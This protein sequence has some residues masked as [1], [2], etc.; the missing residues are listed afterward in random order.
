LRLAP[1]PLLRRWPAWPGLVLLIAA[2]A[3]AGVAYAAALAPRGPGDRSP[4][5]CRG[6]E[7]TIV[8]TAGDDRLVGTP[9]RDVIVAGAGADT[10]VARG[11]ADVVCDNDGSDRV[12]AGAGEDAVGGGAGDD[13]IRGGAGDDWLAGRRGQDVIAGGRGD[14]RLVGDRGPDTLRGNAGDDRLGGGPGNDDCV[15]GDGADVVTEC[16][17]GTPSDPSGPS[18]D[19]PSGPGAPGG[20]PADQPPSAADDVA[21]MPEDSGPRDI[22][23]LTNDPDPDGGPKSIAS[24]SQPANGSVQVTGG[25]TGLTY[26]PD[27]DYC[28]APPGTTD[29]FTYTLAPGGSTASVAVTVTCENDAPSVV[30]S[31]GPLPYTEGAAATAV[32]PLLLLLDAD[33]SQLEGATVRISAGFEAGDELVFTDQPGITGSVAGDTLTLT[34]TATVA[35]YQTALRSV[36]FRHSGDDPSTSRTVLF[37]VDDGGQGS[38]PAFKTIAITPVND[39]PTV[40]VSPGDAEFTEDG[41]RVAVDPDVDVVDPDSTM[42]A[43]ASVALTP[44]AEPTETLAFTAQSGI[45]GGYDPG[46]GV[47]TLIGIATVEDYEAVLRSV[48][49]ARSAQNTVVSFVRF[50]S[51]RVTDAGGLSSPA[52]TRD[53]RFTPVNDAPVVTT[54]NGDTQYLENGPPTPIDDAVTVTDV[55]DLDIEG[56]TVTISEGF[57]AGDELVFSDQN[58]I[59]GTVAGDTLTLSG[60]AT[61]LQYQTALRTTAYRHNGDNPAASR[62]VEFT[63]NDGDA[64]SAPA[65]KN[66]DIIAVNDTPAVDPTDAALAYPEN[67]GPL[68]ADAGIT[69]SDPDSLLQG[70]AVIVLVGFVPAQDELAFANQLGITGIYDDT[71]GTLTLSGTGTVADYQAALR[72]VTYEN[73]SDDPSPPSRTL[74]FRVTDAQGASVAATREVTLGAANDAATIT[75]TAGALAYTEGAVAT[76]VDGGLTVAD[77]D[78][79]NLDGARVRVSAGFDAGDDLVFVNQS[80]ITGVYNNGTGVLTLSGSATISQYQ[81]ALRSVA[82]RSTHDNPATT[83]TVEF[84]ADDGGGLGPAATRNLDVTRVNDAPVVTTT[85]ANL[86]YTENAGPVAIDTG[87]TVTDPDS[88]QLTGATVTIAAPGFSSAQ[89]ELD[90]TDQNGITGAYNDATGVLTLSGTASV[91]NYQTALRSVA[92]TNVSESP[93]ASRTISFQATDSAATSNAATRGIAITAIN[94]PPTAVNDTASTD[95]DTTL[96]VAVPGVLAND[97][98]VDAGDTKTV[99]RLNGN[100]VLTGTSLKGAAVTINANGSYSYNPGSIFQGL[101]TGQSDTDSFTYRMSDSGGASSTATVNLTIIGVSD[102]PVA[103]ADSFD[104]IGNTALSVGTGRPAGEAGKVIT[105]TVLS[106]DTDVDTPQANLVVEPVDNAPTTLGG[107]ITFEADGNFTY[108]P[109]D[110]DVGVTDTFTYRVCDSTPCNSGTVTNSTGTLSLPLAGQVWYVQNN[111]PAGGDGTSDTPFDTIAEAETASGTGDTVYVF[112]GSNTSTNLDTGFVME[113][114]ERLIGEHNGLSLSGHVLHAGTPNAHPTLAAT[115]EDVV[116]LAT[117]ATV[118]GINVDPAGAGGG[119]FGGASVNGSTINDVNVTDAGPTFG[120]QAGIDL[121]G[122]S[123]THSISDLTVDTNGGTGVRLNGN[124]GTVNFAPASTITITTNGAKALDVTNTNLGTSTFDNITVAL[125]GN[126]GVSMSGTAS[127]TTTF[128]NLSLATV[129]GATP[130]FSLANAGTVTVPT[131]ASANISAVGGPAVDVTSTPNAVL[132]FDVVSSTGSSGDG[133]NLANAGSFSATGGTI[134]AASGISFDLDDGSGAISYP[135]N[136]NNGSGLT[137]VEITGRDGGAVLLSGAIGDTNDAGGG[138]NMTGNGGGSST[139][140]SNAS[141]V[142]NTTTSDAVSFSNSDNHTLTLSGGGLDI[143]TTTG[144]GV[145]ASNSGTLVIS[146]T[147]NTIDSVSG[148]GLNVANTDFGSGGATF[149]RISSGNATPD[150]DPANGIVLSGTGATAGLTIT[151]SGNSSVGG[152]GSGGAILGTTGH[153]I[154]LASTLSPSLTNLNIQ[155]TSG[156]GINGTDVTNFTFANGTINGN[157]DVVGESNIAFNGNGSLAGN[158]VDGTVS[159]T[160]SVLTNAFDHG[161]HF[162]NNAGTI[163]NATLTGNTIT[164]STNGAITTGSGLQLIGTGTATTAGSMTRATISGNTIRNFPSGSGI[165]VIYASTIPGGPMATAGIPGDST[166]VIAITGNTVRGQDA[167]NRFNAHAIAAVV[168]GGNSA[169][170]SR[171]N[172]NISNNGTAAQPIGNSLGH[173]INLG[174]NAFATVTMTVNNNFI[175]ANNTL[176]SNGI[177]GGNGVTVGC[178]AGRCETPNLTLTAMNNNIS[179]TDGNGILLV[180][181]GNGTGSILNLS[182]RN[183]TVAAPLTGVRP[184]IR[185]DAG[186]SSSVDDAV[187]LDISGNT[188]AGS[189]GTQ[190]IGLRKEG[191]TATTNDFGIEGMAATGTP[192]VE[193]F[194]NGLNPAGGGTLLISAESGFSNCSTAP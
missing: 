100:V 91:P 106:N 35:D 10:V 47:L 137:A 125:S 187:C 101:S 103:G 153:G 150:A 133:I 71:S 32:D 87:L 174:A 134:S 54:S 58:G 172:F 75:T 154:S 177:S 51:F 44:P 162:E 2:L 28:N 164:S 48:T 121:D 127:S 129:T 104:A 81:T 107:T 166:N 23:V 14:D 112:D 5:A 170:R 24:A 122:T 82:F 74:A 22:L 113:A 135:G 190:G 97:T 117:G 115:A 31:L 9:R 168:S 109:D 76:V 120:L 53:V 62:S 114:N 144:R 15:G 186:N 96:N 55:D 138:I 141:K 119:I 3:A 110:A 140:F 85:V 12:N 171:G 192:G 193:T 37:I 69:V 34:G 124:T 98:D 16:E 126:G 123:G 13:R 128:A 116:V 56:A 68:A 89:D 163:D 30:T 152:D 33:D 8:G 19:T 45:A 92:Y 49:Y 194:V 160:N 57:E 151:G 189:G 60:T 1:P 83:K 139:T 18:P 167:T 175:V 52:A 191:T 66:L 157:G 88:A 43:G 84:S 79:V 21:T 111:E 161:V 130:A 179:A 105:G 73:S 142:L 6:E 102:A 180:G 11:G 65:T 27:P 29:D 176:A 99:D 61:V 181:R 188:S 169:Q 136:L 158:N 39:A 93:S 95:E 59:S 17:D 41:P 143:D 77:P 36:Q 63:V 42:L 155:T 40:S 173:V 46:V 67:A 118:D 145:V 108:H 78:D 94:D 38:P 148:T 70:A 182:I 50:V 7:A 26:K 132:S 146:G 185:V 184:G 147:S 156:S 90:F 64:D 25:G 178:S 72:A 165:Q 149:Q 80:G 131:I 159:V 86:G 20:P 183:N 4:S